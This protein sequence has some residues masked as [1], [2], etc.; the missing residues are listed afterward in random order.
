MKPDARYEFMCLAL[1]AE[2]HLNHEPQIGDKTILGFIT[3]VLKD[4]MTIVNNKGVVHQS[5]QTYIFSQEYL[6]EILLRDTGR[7]ELLSEFYGFA[8]NYDQNNCKKYTINELWL[9]YTMETL[10]NKTW[11]NDDKRWIDIEK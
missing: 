9:I 1:P 3:R 11:D 2:V 8:W 10:M 5:K 4:G 7:C 6:Q